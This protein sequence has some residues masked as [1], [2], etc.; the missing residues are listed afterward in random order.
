MSYSNLGEMFKTICEQY[1]SKVAL[2]YKD[3]KTY[4]SLTFAE[5][6]EITR[7]M[8]AALSKMGVK[9]G[10]RVLLL[11]E[12]RIEWTISD[13][14]ILSLGAVTVPLYPTLLPSHI[15]FIV[16]NSGGKLMLVSNLQ[17]LRK[18]SSIRKKLKN[19]KNIIIMEGDGGKEAKSWKEIMSAGAKML[20]K[21]SRFLDESI[22][23]IKRN[24]VASIIY[25][26]GTT[27]QPK[28]V[29]L[30]HGNFLSNVEGALEFIK[31]SEKDTFLSFLPLSHVFER[32]AGHFLALYCGATIAFAESIE[33]VPENL[34]E[35][36]PTIM[37]S[38]PRFF[39][40]VYARVMEGLE[41]GSAAK[42]K[43]FFWAIEVG[44]RAV[45]YRQ[46]GREMPSTL[47]IKYKLAD[48][49]VFS[50]LKERVGG[51]IRLFISGGAPLSRDINEFF[52]SAGLVL[53][54]GYGLT[55][56]SPVIAV[57]QAE[58]FKFGSVGLPLNNVE[59]AIDSDGEILTRG[60]H[61]MLGYFEDEAA[62]RE[63][64]DEDGFLHTGDIGYLDKDGF[65]Y[66]TDRKKNIIV[67]SGG[68][69]VAPQAIENLLNNSRYIE[70]T[71]VVGDKRKFCSAFIVPNMEN[72]KSW[73]AEK[74]LNVK[75]EEKLL[76]HGEVQQLIRDE[77]DRLSV[78]LASYETIKKFRLLATPFSVE[79]GDLTPT[80]KVKRNVVEQKYRAQIEE[81]Y[82]ENGNKGS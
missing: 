78:D 35:V 16:N 44:K 18:I 25:T 33:T 42:R 67:T 34:Q 28:G 45:L 40:K 47:K 3:N 54:E 1:S 26:S 79:N 75:N 24:D 68:K 46:K 2:M 20:S 13:Y 36:H 7:Q 10:D 52:N 38:V 66:I 59:V 72:L 60:P 43:I 65:L 41:E 62:T 69:N 8:A 58:K 22:A 27:G 73:A 37:T 51:R 9:K 82:A 80:L 30:S 71:V 17:Q 74:G 14:A 64:I 53:L 11:S 76:Q 6:Y 48:R 31:V 29:M 61:V 63:V 39:E 12:N 19:L 57:N 32:M 21:N 55:E 70:Q 77:I 56:T 5:I 50:K 81:I 15:E 4:K 23:G 49:L